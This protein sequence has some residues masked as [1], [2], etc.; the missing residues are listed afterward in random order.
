MQS[1]IPASKEEGDDRRPADVL[2]I[3]WERGRDVAVDL[4]ITHPLGLAGHPITVETAE[5]HCRRAEATKVANEGDLC[6]R[7]G[8]GFIPAAFTPWGG[9]GP[10]ARA[11]LH[12]VGRRA[13]AALEGWPKQRRL[14]EIH[15]GLSLTWAREVARQ[16]SLRN[17]V[18]DAC[19]GDVIIA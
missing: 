14:Q 3:G 19:T 16:L 8:W 12:E 1:A 5:Q 2:L 4:T 6:R 13:T 18:Q 7:L 15:Q 11:L 17:R 9:C 10:S